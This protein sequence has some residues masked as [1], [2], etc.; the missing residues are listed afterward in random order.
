MPLESVAEWGWNTQVIPFDP[1]FGVERGLDGCGNRVLLHDVFLIPTLHDAGSGPGNCPGFRFTQPMGQTWRFK[2]LNGII[3]PR[4]VSC[5]HVYH[6]ATKLQTYKGWRVAP[7]WFESGDSTNQ[8]GALYLDDLTVQQLVTAAE[9]TGETK[10][11]LIRK[12]V[13]EWLARHGQ[14][15]WPDEALSFT[16]MTEMPPFESSRD[17]LNPPAVDPLA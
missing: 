9:R 4:G 3:G 12:A 10:N 2:L 17:R 11:A 5:Y 7:G 6:H 16:G 8:I 14:P 15:Q 13:S 1:A